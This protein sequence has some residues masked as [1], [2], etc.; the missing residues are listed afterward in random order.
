MIKYKIFET[1]IKQDP[2]EIKCPNCHEKG[3]NLRGNYQE[4]VYTCK[5]CL[6]RFYAEYEWE[7]HLNNDRPIRMYTI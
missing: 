4:R 1:G 2:N 3:S 5:K 6:C 7:K